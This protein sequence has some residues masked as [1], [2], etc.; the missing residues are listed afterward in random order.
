MTNSIQEELVFLWSNK[1]R[2]S[3][4]RKKEFYKMVGAS[5]KKEVKEQ[6][7]LLPL[8]KL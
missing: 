6:K 8:N 2:Q 7:K 4:K 1:E 3:E 5:L